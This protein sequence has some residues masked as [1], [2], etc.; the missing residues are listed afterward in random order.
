M[1]PP[2]DPR[3]GRPANIWCSGISFLADGRILVT[4][5]TKEYDSRGTSYTGLQH[6]Y[7]FDPRTRTWQRHEDMRQGRWYPS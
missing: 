1:P 5:G 3:T 2:I 7:T 4:G 6:V